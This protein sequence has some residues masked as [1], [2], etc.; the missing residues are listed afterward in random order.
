M[1]KT[2]TSESFAT[3]VDMFGQMS[4]HM[5]SFWLVALNNTT[6]STVQWRKKGVKQIQSISDEALHTPGTIL[7]SFVRAT[8][9]G[10]YLNIYA[11]VDLDIF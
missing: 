10:S 3:T 8:W 6:V 9:R 7:V 2:N 1:H 4:A 11:Y 5:A